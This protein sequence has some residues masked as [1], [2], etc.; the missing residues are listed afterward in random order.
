REWGVGLHSITEQIDTTTPVGRFNFRNLAS[1]A[2]LERDMI[3][4]RSRMGM[5]A[6]AKQHKWPNPYP[7]MG[8]DKDEDGKL[9]VNEEEADLVRRIFVMYIDRH[10]MPEVAF[11]LNEE[12]IRTKRD[13]EWSAW[14]VKKVLSNEIYI[15]EYE[16]AGVEDYV[17]DYRIIEDSLFEKATEVRYRFK[18]E[19]NEMSEER[20]KKKTD[21]MVDKYL[22][23]LDE[24]EK[25]KAK[26]VE[27]M[28]NIVE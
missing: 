15:G 24:M 21:K 19:Q 6:L 1:A 17:G 5:H 8:Y 25:R 11:E 22:D 23:F 4:Q 13:K 9:V 26:K 20:K 27:G 12:G 10:S 18:N 14:S 7:P 3:K 28:K 16:V 2:E